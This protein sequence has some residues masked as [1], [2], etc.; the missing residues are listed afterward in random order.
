MIVNVQREGRRGNMTYARF[1][2]QEHLG[3]LLGPDEHVDHQNDDHHDDRIGNLQL[4]TPGANTRKSQGE[5]TWMEFICP[6]C[7][8][9]GIQN[10]RHVRNNR[11]KGRA[12][13]FCG[14]SCAGKYSTSPRA[15][16][17]DRPA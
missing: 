4:L 7:G 14:K 9:P 11:K 12:G 3:R 1:L 15:G 2:M 13:P 6:Q 10:A 8:N 17:V 16:T 5:I